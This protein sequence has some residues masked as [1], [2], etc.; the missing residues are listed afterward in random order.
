[1]WEALH[2]YRLLAR[3]G[4]WIWF[5]G[6]W[7]TQFQHRHAGLYNKSWIAGIVAVWL[8][9]T[10]RGKNAP[11]LHYNPRSDTGRLSNTFRLHHYLFRAYSAALSW[12]S[13]LRCFVRLQTVAWLCGESEREGVRWPRAQ[14][15]TWSVYQHTQRVHRVWPHWGRFRGGGVPETLRQLFKVLPESTQAACMWCYVM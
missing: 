10:S 15:L 2:I 11:R 7:G 13:L 1:M 3:D 8:S 5:N 4:I 12:D 9:L 14:A 6:Q